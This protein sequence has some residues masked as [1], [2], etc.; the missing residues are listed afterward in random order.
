MIWKNGRFIS[1]W[2]LAVA[3][4]VKPA[5]NAARRKLSDTCSFPLQTEGEFILSGQRQQLADTSTK[6]ET[7]RRLTLC[8]YQ[9]SVSFTDVSKN[10]SIHGI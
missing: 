7:S 9:Y 10:A 6:N 1:D 3:P 8:S 4:G 2:E 5:C